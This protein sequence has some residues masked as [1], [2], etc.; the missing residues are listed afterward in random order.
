VVSKT[1][2]SCYPHLSGGESCH[3]LRVYREV[4]PLF[5]AASIP[6]NICRSI[7][8]VPPDRLLGSNGLMP[9]WTSST[10]GK[11]FK[12]GVLSVTPFRQSLL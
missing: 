4:F 5:V 9:G 7:G 11:K 1:R 3:R 12:S 8:S 10:F 6:L 2:H